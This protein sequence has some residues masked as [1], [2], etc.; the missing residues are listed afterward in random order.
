MV[1]LNQVHFWELRKKVKKKDLNLT[2]IPESKFKR[3]PEEIWV[4]LKEKV[5]GEVFSIVEKEFDLIKKIKIFEEYS[6]EYKKKRNKNIFLF[7]RIKRKGPS[8]EVGFF[9]G[10]SPNNEVT[11]GGRFFRIKENALSFQLVEEGGSLVPRFRLKV[12]KN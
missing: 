6:K 12:D 11:N 10:D 4:P 9:V 1:N 7:L 5:E 2:G 8:V 3:I